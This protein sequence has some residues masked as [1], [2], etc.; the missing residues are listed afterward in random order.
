[1]VGVASAISLDRCTS[2][3]TERHSEHGD[4]QVNVP[5]GINIVGRSNS[6]GL[7]RDA[8]LMEEILG[9]AGRQV[10]FSHY[11]SR[12]WMASFLPSRTTFE[13]TV[14]LERVFPRWFGTS[15]VNLLVPNQERFP[16]RHIR[17]LESVDHVLCK[18]RHAEAIFRNLGCSVSYIG[19]TSR[20]RFDQNVTMDY[21]S[22]FHLAGRSTLKGTEA[23][24]RL[25]KKHP[26]WPEL[27]LVQRRK[28][29]L[30]GLPANVKLMP[31]HLDDEELRRL[32][33]GRGIHLCP[34]LAEG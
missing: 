8:S 21:R 27:L 33:N 31:R 17:R 20:D 1:M 25:W 29:D 7:D 26:E 19:F 3:K 24:L 23:V 18:T 13:G 15:S 6:V 11:R 2:S 5:S 4:P 16:R 9:D 28:Q 30:D 10:R 14:F 34:S 22:V 32:Q 12:P